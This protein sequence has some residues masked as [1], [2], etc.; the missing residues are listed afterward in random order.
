MASEQVRTDD[1]GRQWVERRVPILPRQSN[2]PYVVA[3]VIM[4]GLAIVAVAAIAVLRPDKDNSSLFLTIGGFI[5]PTTFSLLSFLKAQDTHKS[6]NGRLEE[7]L[8]ARGVAAHAQGVT[9]GRQQGRQAADDRTDALAATASA[10]T[11]PVAPVVVD[12]VVPVPAVPVKKG[13]LG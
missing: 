13:W 9:E 7:F 11:P 3:V 6:V 12:V 4:A 8:A 2:M 1:T 5:G 10:A